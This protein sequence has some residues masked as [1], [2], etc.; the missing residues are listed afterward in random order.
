MS[1]DPYLQVAAPP[2][3]PGEGGEVVNPADGEQPPAPEESQA[4]KVINLIKSVGT[5]A[6]MMYFVMSF[7]KKPQQQ[8]GDL[9]YL[10]SHSSYPHLIAQSGAVATVN[11]PATNLYQDGM[12][13]DLY[14]FL[15]EQEEFGDFQ[16]LF[17]C[18]FML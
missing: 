5:Q 6:L 9:Q 8:P 1:E 7:F 17:P 10:L 13:F 18:T 14:V 16:V 4:T 3:V 2:P 11:S 15:S 12:S